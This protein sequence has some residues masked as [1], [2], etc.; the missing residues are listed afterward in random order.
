M[1]PNAVFNSFKNALI[2]SLKSIKAVVEATY[3]NS[4]LLIIVLNNFFVVLEKYDK[5]SIMLSR[6][7]S[8]LASELKIMRAYIADNGGWKCILPLKIRSILLK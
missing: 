6:D 1:P 3:Y 7:I 4:Q 2:S 8:Y 5:I